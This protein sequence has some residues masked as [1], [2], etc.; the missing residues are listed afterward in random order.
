MYAVFIYFST[1]KRPLQAKFTIQCATVGDKDL[2]PRPIPVLAATLVKGTE[3]SVLLAY[4]S[5]LKPT[6]EKVVSM[7]NNDCVIVGKLQGPNAASKTY[8]SA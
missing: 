1:L 2:T 5:F 8:W 6:F 3:P 4:G 7:V